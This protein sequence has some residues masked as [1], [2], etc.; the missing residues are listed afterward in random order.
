MSAA[1]AGSLGLVMSPG[2]RGSY[3][4]VVWVGR[5]VNPD[6]RFEQIVENTQLVGVCHLLQCVRSILAWCAECRRRT[7]DV[8]KLK[9]RDLVRY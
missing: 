8:E 9:F 7:R 4:R 5:W 3:G 2:R 1:A 6:V